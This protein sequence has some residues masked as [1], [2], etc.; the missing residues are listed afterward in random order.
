MVNKAKEKLQTERRG[1]KTRTQW[2]VFGEILR[3]FIRPSWYQKYLISWNHWDKQKKNKKNCENKYSSLWQNPNW[4]MTLQNPEDK[5]NLLSCDFE[6]DCS[7]F[8][9]GSDVI[10]DIIFTDVNFSVIDFKSKTKH[11]HFFMGVFRDALYYKTPCKQTKYISNVRKIKA[12]QTGAEH[13]VQ[14]Q[15]SEC[16][17]QIRSTV[18]NFLSNMFRKIFFWHWNWET[19]PHTVNVSTYVIKSL[20]LCLSGNLT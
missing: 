3:S 20:H 12:W 16:T 2:V 19:A 17:E 18:C 9:L 13:I 7:G 4:G 8:A 10:F 6:A 1:F 14:I 5:I 15:C 11:S